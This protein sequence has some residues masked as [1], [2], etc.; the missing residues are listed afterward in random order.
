VPDLTFL[1]EM[2]R[3][4]AKGHFDALGSHPYGGRD[5]PDTPPAAASG[6]IYFRRAEEQHQVMLEFGDQSPVWITEFGW[7][8][9]TECNLGEHEWMQVSEDQQAK[10]LAGA[11]DY[12]HLNWPWMGPMFL[13]NLDFGTVYW[14][15]PCDPVRWYSIQYRGNPQD[16][17]NSPI[18]NRAA[19]KALQDMA[20]YSAW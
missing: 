9:A 1:R 12:A 14:Y 8:L 13:F 17:G 5:A 19:F 20:K 4:G 7:V 18:L 15:A 16:P 3:H 2:Y 6:P 11:Y 10:Y